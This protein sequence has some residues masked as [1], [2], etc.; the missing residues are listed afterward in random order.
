MT[1]ISRSGPVRGGATSRR[2]FLLGTAAAAVTIPVLGSCSSSDDESRVDG[3]TSTTGPPVTVPEP[4]NRVDLDVDPFTLGVASGDPESTSVV[5]WTRLAPDPVADDGFGGMPDEPADVLWEVASDPGFETLRAAGLATTDSDLAHS[6]HVVVDGL[7]PGER[8][9]YR[10]RCGSWT[11]PVGT[12]TSLPGASPADYRIA[13]ANCQ[14]YES[15]HWAAYRAMSEEQP[16]LV[17]HLGDYI[18]EYPF[19]MLEGRTPVPDRFLTTLADYRIRYGCYKREP[20]L[21]E[22]HSVAP[23]VTTWDDHEVANNYNGDVV[24]GV[25]G[26]DEGRKRKAAAYRAW[27]EHTPTRQPAPDGSELT[28][29]QVLTVGELFRLHLLDERQYAEVPPCRTSAAQAML[30]LGSC[31]DRFEERTRLGADQLAWLADNLDEGG[32]RWNILGN[33]VV[34]AGVNVGTDD[35]QFYLD[36]WDGYVLERRRVTELLAAVD[37]PIVLTGDYH[38]G[39]TLA[40]HEDPEDP[41]SPVVAPEFLSPPISSGLFSQDASARTPHLLEQINAHGYLT[42]DVTDEELTVAFRCVD[43][44]TDRDSPVRTRSTWRVRPG[45]PVPQQI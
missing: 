31:D 11:S 15:G 38:A 42:V 40:V 24:V 33:P 30:D 32:V 4:V 23:F 41:D 22:I 44:V 35:D 19:Q 29:H 10:F 17:V 20:E 3:T 7:E 27:W 13:V 28:V 5:I 9:H 25:D 45:D 18:Y 36:T 14:M 12:T 1:S 16:D 8:I 21:Q 26:P 34:L 43:E 37:N 2:S 6:I 39:M